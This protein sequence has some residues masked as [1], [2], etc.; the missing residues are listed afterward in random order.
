MVC[1]TYMSKKAPENYTLF[2]TENRE[3]YSNLTELNDKDRLPG[4]VLNGPGRFAALNSECM[5]VCE[6]AFA[7][8]YTGI[9]F[10][11]SG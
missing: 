3:I 2:K 8:A 5:G 9:H 10:S 7:V 1:P 4:C 11:S 6:G